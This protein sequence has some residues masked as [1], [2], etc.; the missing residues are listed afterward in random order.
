[1]SSR[2]RVTTRSSE[3]KRPPGPSAQTRRPEV[4][5][6][7]LELQRSLGNAA[8]AKLLRKGPAPPRAGG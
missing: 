8:V 5:A 1:M 7:V 3:A 2:Q 4:A 6:H